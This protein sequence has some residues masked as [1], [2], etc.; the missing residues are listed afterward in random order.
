MHSGQSLFKGPIL[1][2]A[3][4]R[5]DQAVRRVVLLN[6]IVTLTVLLYVPDC[7]AGSFLFDKGAKCESAA[8]RYGFQKEL[9][10]SGDITLLAYTRITKADAPLVIYIE[11]DGSAWDSRAK[12]S[13]DPTPRDTIVIDLAATDPSA[14]VIYLARPGQYTLEGASECSPSY[15]S[16]E[17]FSET[18]VKAMD[19]AID[20]LKRKYS[21]ASL[22]L[23]GY[24]GGGAI[25]V[26][27]AARR[28]DVISLRT[29]AGNL[30]T[31]A[32]ALYHK[33]SPLTGSLNPMDV[34][35][36]IKDLPQRH[37]VGSKDA[38]IPISV[39]Q[40]FIKRAGDAD[41]ERITVVDGATHSKGW[42]EHWQELL[43]IKLGDVSKKGAPQAR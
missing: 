2:G 42:R 26:L 28:S 23:V 19:C 25:A 30:D 8:T 32:V 12:L 7:S 21:A 4:L 37:F 10:D 9:V 40:S 3:L 33:V 5:R 31:E 24:S 6:I 27:V 41:D 1:L 29:I 14:N 15:W 39:V 22:S 18:A 20:C 35:K 17:R 13:D 16:N 43:S 38:V 36:K 11:G 34:A